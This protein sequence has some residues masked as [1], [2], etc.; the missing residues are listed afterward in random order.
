MKPVVTEVAFDH[1]PAHIIGLPADTVQRGRRHLPTV[2][3]Q[4]RNKVGRGF[5]WVRGKSRGKPDHM[6][7]KAW[8]SLSLTSISK[9]FISIWLLSVI[10]NTYTYNIVNDVNSCFLFNSTVIIDL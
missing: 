2:P 5:G 8:Q 3:K 6:R 10:A 7:K 4:R 9:L 1:K